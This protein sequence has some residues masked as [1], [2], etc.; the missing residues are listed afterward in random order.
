MAIKCLV[1]LQIRRVDGV[2]QLCW[3]PRE[4]LAEDIAT[5]SH[6]IACPDL[7]TFMAAQSLQ[8]CPP[9]TAVSIPKQTRL[10]TNDEC[11]IPKNN[12]C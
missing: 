10:K 7:A 9:S 4:G 8:Y 11:R 1:D 3:R 12:Q 2:A 6:E 5:V